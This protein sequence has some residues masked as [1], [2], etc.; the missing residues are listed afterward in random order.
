MLATL[1][2]ASSPPVAS[3]SPPPPEPEARLWSQQQ[4]ASRSRW[5]QCSR[6]AAAF[7]SA[8][9]TGEES[10][11]DTGHVGGTFTSGAR[12]HDWDE[13]HPASP[14]IGNFL[15]QYNDAAFPTDLEYSSNIGS[16][17]EKIA[18]WI[19]KFAKKPSIWLI[20]A[21]LIVSATQMRPSSFKQRSCSWPDTSR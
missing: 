16:T 7:G 11:S 10:G 21:A 3:E 20:I 18:S 9:K 19:A 8:G 14:L 5:M 17:F 15:S 2:T 12:D 1:R 6:L 4:E 13:T